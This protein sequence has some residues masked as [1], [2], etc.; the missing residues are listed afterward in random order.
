M[1]TNSSMPLDCTL[2][3]KEP[4]INIIPKQMWMASQITY[5]LL[6]LLLFQSDLESRKKE[7]LVILAINGY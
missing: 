2:I 6:P 7:T 4:S 5:V 1:M 3:P